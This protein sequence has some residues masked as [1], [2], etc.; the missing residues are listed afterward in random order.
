M[1]VGDRARKSRN[2]ILFLSYPN[3]QTNSLQNRL[4]TARKL[5]RLF[6]GFN[7]IFKIEDSL[8][9]TAAVLLL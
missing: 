7:D 6:I 5:R 1:M 3:P 8:W 9:P 2:G 4:K